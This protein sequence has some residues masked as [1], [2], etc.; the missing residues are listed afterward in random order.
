MTAKIL[1]GKEVADSIKQKVADEVKNLK[2]EH[3]FRPGLTVVRVGEDSASA[4]YV[5]NKVK[6]SEELGLI[7]EHIHLPET[8][9]QN[10]LLNL[11]EELNNRDDVDGIL[12][13][14]PLPKQIDEKTILE[15]IDPAKDVTVFIRSTSDDF[16]RVSRRSFR[17]L[18]PA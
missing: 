7:S 1:S 8:T 6:T 17:V 15:V 12:V 5:G 14:L 9:T 18:Q 11:V 2:A 4:V 13:Q 10:E 16:R 3:D